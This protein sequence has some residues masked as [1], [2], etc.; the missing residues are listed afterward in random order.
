MSKLARWLSPAV[1]AAALAVSPQ[2]EAQVLTGSATA[3]DGDSL[4]LGSQRVRLFGIDAPELDQT[5][6]TNGTAWQ[7]GDEAKQK[8]NELVVGQRVDCQI[9]GMDQYGRSLGK[10][11]TEFLELNEALV[12][13]G[14]AVAYREYSLDYVEAEARAKLR[15]AG[16]WSST[17]TTPSA[18][19]LANVP[20]H[21]APLPKVSAP[22][23]QLSNE[24]FAGC[25]IKGNRNRKGQWIYHLPGMPYYD[26]TRAEE[27]FC[28]EAQAR[29]AGYR[30]AIVK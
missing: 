9:T 29:A 20:K 10:C 13:L 19:R 16:I 22:S 12:E 5:C 8:L 6:H 15:K 11:S 23:P 4:V 3:A 14:W 1:V 17:F 18:H 24:S 28:T 2:A 7:C 25:T 26:R 30:R 27:F 21:S